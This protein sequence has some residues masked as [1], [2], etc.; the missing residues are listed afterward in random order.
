MSNMS[1][2]VIEPLRQSADTSQFSCGEDALDR[3]LKDLAFDQQKKGYGKT[4]VAI[5]PPGDSVLGFYTLTATQIEFKNAPK[6]L[7]RGMPR[8]PVPCFLLARLAVDQKSQGRG[9]GRRLVADAF[10]RSV[11]AGVGAKCLLVDAKNQKV[12]G[13]YRRLG[14]IPFP[15][16]PLK[17]FIKMSTIE[18][19]LNSRK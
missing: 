19:A 12:A 2:F 3:F 13:F 9:L 5:L 14:F 6:K 10:E 8:Y 18:K 17:L 1:E 15:D 11:R 16:Q 7:I 4:W